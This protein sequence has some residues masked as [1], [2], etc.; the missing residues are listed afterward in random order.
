M[1]KDNILIFLVL[2]KR[3]IK[4]QKKKKKLLLSSHDIPNTLYILSPLIF[5]LDSARYMLTFPFER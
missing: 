5:Q 3:K 4:Y 1:K 2:K